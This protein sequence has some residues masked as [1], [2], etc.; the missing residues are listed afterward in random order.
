MSAPPS[1]ADIAERNEMS[2][3]QIGPVGVKRFQTV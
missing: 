3:S 1:K 2:A